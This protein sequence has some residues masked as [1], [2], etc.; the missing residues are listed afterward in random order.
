[1]RPWTLPEGRQRGPAASRL[2]W[3]R[4]TRSGRA[5]KASG[6]ACSSARLRL[7]R[8]RRPGGSYRARARLC[9][10]YSAS[11]AARAPPAVT[12]TGLAC[13]AAQCAP[14]LCQGRGCLDTVLGCV[15]LCRRAVPV[16]GPDVARATF[17]RLLRREPDADVQRGE[18]RGRRLPRG[19]LPGLGGRGATLAHAHRHH[20]HRWGSLLWRRAEQGKAVSR[21]AGKLL[22]VGHGHSC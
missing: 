9:S 6:R 7:V 20:P 4:R 5:R 8:A 17:A 11:R 16:Q 12:H 21:G 22:R 10:A 15:C 14:S 2:L 13:W 18:R 19:G 1:M 3:L